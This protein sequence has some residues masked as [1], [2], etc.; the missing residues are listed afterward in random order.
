MCA[1]YPSPDVLNHVITKRFSGGPS[2][3]VKLGRGNITIDSLSYS[4]FSYKTF[5]ITILFLRISKSALNL[6]LL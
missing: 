3:L 4:L 1:L 6:T 2:L 5:P